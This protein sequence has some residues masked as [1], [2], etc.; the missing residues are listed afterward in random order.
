LTVVDVEWNDSYNNLLKVDYAKY[1]TPQADFEL[2]PE[3][4]LIFTKL[5]V[6][7]F[8]YSENKGRILGQ[9]KN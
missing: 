9:R 7:I 1:R 4:Q 3:Q 6:T 2:T 5:Q 8:N